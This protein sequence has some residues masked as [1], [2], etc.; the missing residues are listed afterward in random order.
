MSS[1]MELI[2]RC[3]RT[4]QRLKALEWMNVPVNPDQHMKAMAELYLARDAWAAA[5]KEYR[6]AI[7]TMSAAELEALS[8]EIGS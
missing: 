3:E 1:I 5:D 7:S 2:E 6:E 4:S 8:M